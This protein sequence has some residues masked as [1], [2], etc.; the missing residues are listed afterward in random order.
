MITTHPVSTR[1]AAVPYQAVAT[2]VERA[3]EQGRSGS[4]FE[5]SPCRQAEALAG[6]MREQAQRCGGHPVRAVPRRTLRSVSARRPRHV[7]EGSDDTR[8]RSVSATE[9]SL[10]VRRLDKL[11]LRD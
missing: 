7:A 5:E 8:R 4:T 1:P 6:C 11:E 9:R 2:E 10:F 3:E